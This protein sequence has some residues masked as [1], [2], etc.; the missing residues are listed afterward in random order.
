[1]SPVLPSMVAIVGTS[2][3]GGGAVLGTHLKSFLE[4]K[5]IRVDF[6]DGN[7]YT[8]RAYQRVKNINP[9]ERPS[10]LKMVLQ[11]MARSLKEKEY[12]LIIV[13]E[14]EDILL[15]E[16]SPKSKVIYYCTCTISFER[17][18][19]WLYEG[20]QKAEEKLKRVLEIERQ[21]Y[22]LADAVIFA[23]PTYEAFV[24]R[25]VYDG[26][27]I[28]SHP[29]KGW[30]GCEPDLKRVAFQSKLNMIYLGHI[31]YWSNPELLAQLTAIAPFPI[32]AYGKAN[33]P[34]PGIEYFGYAPDLDR[35][36]NKF[37]Y[38]INTVSKDPLRHAGFSSK[39]LTFLSVGLPVFSPD[40]QEFSH[41]VS[42]VIPYNEKNF[43]QLVDENFSRQRWQQ[44]SDA[45]YEQAQELSWTKILGPLLDLIS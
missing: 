20:D 2:I 3:L 27:N 31:F 6:Y 17:Y 35:L 41:Q 37:A 26:E 7:L 32:H 14:R 16:L 21:I 42:G 44:L 22:H 13:I 10:N 11:D 18:Y 24:K 39:V 9:K 45:A 12:P 43:L 30:Y 38:G 33:V 34:V 23:W 5:G 1:M 19:G 40:W 29:G 8:L 25:N 15:E 28:V 4:S 36:L